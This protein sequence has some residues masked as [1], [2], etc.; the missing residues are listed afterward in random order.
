MGAA[1]KMKAIMNYEQ[2]QPRCSSCAH[3]S[4]PQKPSPAIIIDGKEL[5]PALRHIPPHCKP[6]VDEHGNK[7][8]GFAVSQ[9]GICDHWLHATTGEVI[10]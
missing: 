3:Y 7:L 10:E 2:H 1:Q 6:R 4:P 5:A 9:H 8:G